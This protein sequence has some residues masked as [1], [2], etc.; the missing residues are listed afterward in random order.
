MRTR[1]LALAVPVLLALAE[2]AAAQQ[3]A[4]TTAPPSAQS[5]EPATL[6]AVTVTAPAGGPQPAISPD[7]EK[8]ALPQTIESIDQRKIA[9]TIN[10]VDSEDAL[11]YMPSL[12]VRKR[13]YGDTQPTFSTRTWGINS[14]ARN[15]VYV[16]DIPI[17][18]LIA[19]N[20]TNGAPRW[21]MV[22]PEEIKGVDMLYGPFAAAYP[23]NSMGGVLMITTR[24]PETFEATAKQTGAFQTFD[25][26][27]TNGTF[28]TSNSAAT[29]GGKLDRF[30][31]FLAGDRL[32]SNS[33]PLAFVTN[34][35]TPG[36]T[37]TIPQLTKNGLVANVVGA[38]GLLHST[39]NNL[40]AK[41]ALDVTDW[42]RATY[43]VGY[44]TNNT[45]SSVQTYLTD[46]A[47]NQTFGGVSSF[48]S[49]TY[50]LQ[51]QH[52]MN[53]LSLKTDTKGAWDFEAIATWYSY[54]QD[55]QRNPAGVLSGANFTT[56]GL[57]ARLDGTGW[58]T[59]DLKGIW[60]PFG[61]GG[62]HEVSFGAHHDR[63]TLNNPTYNTPNWITS[64]DSGNGTL[65]KITTAGAY[66]VLS[67]FDTTHG[68]GA[69]ATPLQHTNGKI[70]GL[71]ARGGASG[72]GVAYSLDNGIA[73]FV[74]LTTTVGLAGKSVGII[75]G[76]FTGTT[77][78]KFNGAS[79]NFTVVSDTYLTAKVPAGETGIVSVTTP[80]RILLSSKIYR[81]TPKI[82][83]L[84][85]ISGKVGSSVV[86]AGSG[87]IH[88]AT[89]TVGGVKVTAFTVN[90]DKQVTFT[91][92]TGAK[93]GKVVLTTAG[94]KATSSAVFTVTP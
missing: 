80:S 7:V 24:M 84:T 30:S 38:G 41:V 86:I 55:I 73:P 26:Y 12:F 58:S 91:V 39:M 27:K 17:S 79:A 45:Q 52:L 9:D 76:G 19:N 21:G 72:K 50:N 18:A 92:P 25:M 44:W 36:T 48:A 87:L 34:G 63:Y 3:D 2:S 53:A 61:P 67:N 28:G 49:N 11:K 60:R 59:Q 64:S 23:G 83:S 8:F 13:N 93:T 15:L 81:V 74:A 1:T 37:G 77:S 68:A 78:V 32:D 66:T 5:A 94:G 42:L 46:G 20:N 40:K 14:S 47:G 65:F 57:I 51:E 29:V 31:F 82:M 6:P 33:Q 71:S 69:Y 62:A 70:F 16:D 22:S 54:M 85:P 4:P 75:G 35:T 10:I 88:A 90:S 43:M 56:N 89:I